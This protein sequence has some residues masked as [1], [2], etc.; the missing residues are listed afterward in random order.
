[1]QELQL[2]L[3][4]AVAWPTPTPAASSS[5]S[6]SLAQL[7]R[8]VL[9]NATGAMQQ[10]GLPALQS[11]QQLHLEGYD[12]HSMGL[13]VVLCSP[14][15]TMLSLG[16]AEVGAFAAEGGLADVLKGTAAAAAAAAA[17][18][19]DLPHRQRGQLAAPHDEPA[20]VHDAI[21]NM[22]AAGREG[23]AATPSQ[24][25][26]QLHA[27]PTQQLSGL[28]ELR[29]VAPCTGLTSSS[30][31]HQQAVKHD[32]RQGSAAAAGQP[33]AINGVQLQRQQQQ[34]QDDDATAQLCRLFSCLQHLTS[35]KLQLPPKHNNIPN[36]TS[37]V[38]CDE[39]ACQPLIAALACLPSLKQLQLSGLQ[40]LPAAAAA[41]AASTAAAAAAASLADLLQLQDLD[42][43]DCSFNSNGSCSSSSNRSSRSGATESICVDGIMSDTAAA[44]A[45]A[46]AELALPCNLTR[47]RWVRCCSDGG[48]KLPQLP[49][50]QLAAGLPQLQLLLLDRQAAGQAGDLLLQ[51]LADRGCKVVLEG[52]G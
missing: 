6:S 37:H 18:A 24:Q 26:L 43:Q 45:A 13:K 49:V 38:A 21:S 28:R 40:E 30:Q 29:I 3:N 25:Q 34:W 20:Q 16:F 46:V 12:L 11:L 5:S 32:A 19:V 4:C 23:S 7:T 10:Q 41:A 44:A 47:L 50:R 33:A 15:L 42:M 22:A 36:N 27:V 31:N 48:E 1:L 39:N 9:H 8:L 17:A 35:F 14:H 52:Q 2:R 51:Q